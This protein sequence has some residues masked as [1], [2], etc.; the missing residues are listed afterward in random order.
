MY[1]CDSWRAYRLLVLPGM[2]RLALFVL[3]VVAG[4]VGNIQRSARVPHP[5][6]PLASGQPLAAPAEATAGLS[7]VTDLMQPRV[8][9]AT[10]AVEVPTTQARGDLRF[11]LHRANIGLVYEHGFGTTA[12]RPDPT[13]APVGD[14]DVRGYGLTT[15]YSF[16]TGVEGFAIGTTLETVLWSVPYVEYVTCTNCV[17]P[18]YTTVD[19]GRANPMTIGLG[20]TPSYKTGSV[21]L[22]GGAFARNHPTT[23][24]KE[25]HTDVTFSDDGDVQDGPMNLL[26]HAGIEVELQKWLSALALVHQDLT[27]SP[28]RYGPGIGVALVARLGT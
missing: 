1:L 18:T 9:D 22:F 13:Q 12:V 20:V 2:S 28:V 11:K 6:V 5:T 21:T 16:P 24:R 14:G 26:V 23:Q 4:C 17:D 10:Q 19:R 3:P 8:G 15:G 27:A 7:N 25:L